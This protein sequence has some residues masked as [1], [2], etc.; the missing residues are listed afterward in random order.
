MTVLRNLLLAK[1]PVIR[2]VSTAK[3]QIHEFQSDWR[4]NSIPNMVLCLVNFF[5]CNDCV[6]RQATPGSEVHGDSSRVTGMSFPSAVKRSPKKTRPPPQVATAGGSRGS[7]SVRLRSCRGLHGDRQLICARE[8]LWSKDLRR[9]VD[10][11]R[12]HRDRAVQ[13]HQVREFRKGSCRPH[14]C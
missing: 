1:L 6:S 13:V 3:F 4:G 11:S 9:D 7:L 5:A 10:G 2:S 14:R 8:R 12:A